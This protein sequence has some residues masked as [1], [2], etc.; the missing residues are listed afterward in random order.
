MW[1]EFQSMPQEL[2]D[3]LGGSIL[4]R[5]QYFY[6]NKNGKVGIVKLNFNL[7]FYRDKLWNHCWEAC[8]NLELRRFPTKKEAEKEIYKV[9]KEKLL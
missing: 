3:Q 9:L 4:G 8:G 6:E 7:N 1:T 2:K 5:W